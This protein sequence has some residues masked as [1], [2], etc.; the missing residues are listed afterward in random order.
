[1]VDGVYSGTCGYAVVMNLRRK[2]SRKSQAADLLGN[3]LKI[4]AATK[5]AKGAKKAAKGTAAYKTAQKAPVVGRVP[6]IAAG[7][8]AVAGT[9]ALVV[10]K[11][12][13]G[14]DEESSDEE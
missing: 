13:G 12:R 7:T 10:A 9:A 1:M 14:K 11:A 2:K 6:L 4:E 3:Y 8:A 5:A